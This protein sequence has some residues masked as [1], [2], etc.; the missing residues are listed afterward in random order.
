[1]DT[2]FKYLSS[3]ITGVSKALTMGEVPDNVTSGATVTIGGK[4]VRACPGIRLED[5]AG[6][7]CARQSGWIISYDT[8]LSLVDDNYFWDI[9]TED[10]LEPIFSHFSN[11]ILRLQAERNKDA[12]IKLTPEERAAVVGQ[13]FD[14]LLAN[15]ELNKRD[16][17][18][19]GYLVLRFKLELRTTAE[20]TVNDTIHNYAKRGAIPPVIVTPQAMEFL[21]RNHQLIELDNP[22]KSLIFAPTLQPIMQS[23]RNEEADYHPDIDEQLSEISFNQDSIRGAIN[24][25]LDK[26]VVDLGDNEELQEIVSDLNDTVN[27]QRQL[28]ICVSEKHNKTDVLKDALEQRFREQHHDI[29]TLK[30]ELSE[31]QNQ[32]AQ[33]SNEIDDKDVQISELKLEYESKI[34]VLETEIQNYQEK[35]HASGLQVPLED[36]TKVEDE[37]ADRE[38]ELKERRTEHQKLKSRIKHLRSELNQ[39]VDEMQRQSDSL[40][41]QK[42]ALQSQV[43]NNATIILAKEEALANV[44]ADNVKLELEKTELQEKINKLNLSMDA[45]NKR[46]DTAVR[47]TRTIATSPGY[48]KLSRKLSRKLSLLDSDDEMDISNV[49]NFLK[50]APEQRSVI[51]ALSTKEVANFIPRWGTDDN[52]VAYCKKIENAWELCNGEQFSQEK[53]CQ[54]LRL[55]LPTAPAQVYDNMTKEERKDVTNVVKALLSRLGRQE[56]EYLQEFSAIKKGPLETHNSFALRVQ[57]V[58]ALGT[59]GITTLTDRDNKLIVEAYL[60]GLPTSESTALRLVASDEEMNSVDKLAIR[61]SRTSRTQKPVNAVIPKQDGYQSQFIPKRQEFRGRKINGPC[62][63]CQVEGHT[64]R[65]CYQRVKN[66]ISWKPTNPWK[67]RNPTKNNDKNATKKE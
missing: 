16:V 11:A 2:R 63:Y 66:D 32:L 43:S 24:T 49:G 29:N 39:K 38:V 27:K 19:I 15:S 64:W 21:F 50:S 42:D 56:N 18:S 10:S 1:M 33:K 5:H 30:Q 26:T 48:K 47:A 31:Q 4:Q 55:H 46:S 34:D 23:T 6:L 62:Y 40:V 41:Q 67:S 3:L 14:Q 52:I 20:K 13:I 61:A 45:L 54:I 25:F 28:I 17:T 60:N 59:G 37:L 57:R 36:L 9:K 12:K 58:Y 22:N 51:A 44:R 8:L 35:Q 53:F 7:K 65:R